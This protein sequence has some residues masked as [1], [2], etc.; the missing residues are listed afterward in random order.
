ML[1]NKHIHPTI[2]VK[3]M[4]KA[5]DFY[6]GVLG[7]KPSIDAPDACMYDAGEGTNF[8]VYA[9]AGPSNGQHTV[10]GFK[11]DDI[12]TEVA[13]LKSKGV[14]FEEYDLPT[15]KTVGS[16]ADTGPIRA[17]W[18]RDPEGNILGIVQLPG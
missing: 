6:E 1:T 16:I 11:V 10:M 18:L 2:P 9:S 5:R 4:A 12:E 8:L 17:A 3:D 14:T 7:F 15:L 13:E